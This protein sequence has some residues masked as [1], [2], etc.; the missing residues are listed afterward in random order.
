MNVNKAG[1]DAAP[2]VS[3]GLIVVLLRVRD[4]VSI[5]VDADISIGND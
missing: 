2:V 5:V 4:E 1:A 3:S